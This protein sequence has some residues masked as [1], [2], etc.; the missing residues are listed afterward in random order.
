[1]RLVLRNFRA[2]SNNNFYQIA[3]FNDEL[4]DL[5]KSVRRFAD[6]RVAPLAA[7][8]DKEDKFPHHL[9]R[10]FGEM[11]LLGVTTSPE[12]GGSGLNY[13]AHSLIMEEISRASGAIGLSYGAHTA[14]CLAQVTR[15]GN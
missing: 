2:F 11:G 15:H 4:V 10:E 12:Y 13:T 6:E 1:M 7:K 5:Q 14:L 9:W 8:T 3:N